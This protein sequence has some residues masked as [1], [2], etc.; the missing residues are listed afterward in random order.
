V[1]QSPAVQKSP[2]TSSVRLVSREQMSDDMKHM[3]ADIACRAFEIFDAHGRR[4]GHDLDDWH[5]A[6]SELLHA[7]QVDLADV[8]NALTARVEMPGFSEKDIEVAV[9]PRRLTIGGRRES[10]EERRKGKTLHQFYRAMDLPAEVDPTSSALRATYEHG[11]LTL[12]LPKMDTITG[13]RPSAG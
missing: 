7:V 5:Q 6:E 3:F 2:R 8:D 4:V 10:W 1:K 12:T 11:V 13:R 9:E